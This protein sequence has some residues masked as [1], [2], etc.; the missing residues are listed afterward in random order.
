MTDRYHIIL[1]TQ[2]K[3][4]SDSAIKFYWSSPIYIGIRSGRQY[5]IDYR[6]TDVAVE[7]LSSLRIRVHGYE[8]GVLPL[9][10]LSVKPL[11]SRGLS[12]VP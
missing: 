3:N 4:L 1:S 2:R 12:G 11:E 10:F 5:V 6:L 7:V 8:N 9:I